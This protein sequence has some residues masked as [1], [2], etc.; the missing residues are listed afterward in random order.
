MRLWYRARTKKKQESYIFKIPSEWVNTPH[1]KIRY[2]KE[3]D[4]FYIASFGE[5]IIVNEKEIGR[6]DMQDPQ[7]TDLPMNSRI[8]LN[9]IVGINIFNS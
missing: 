3:E 4:K 7:W 9:G 1:L 2:D 6:S 5:K 8:V